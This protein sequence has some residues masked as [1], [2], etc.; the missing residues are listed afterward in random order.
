VVQTGSQQ[1]SGPQYAKARELVRSGAIGAVHRISAGFARN[2]TPGFVAREIEG[3][4]PGTLDWEMWLGPAPAAAFD[5]FRCIYNFRWFWHYSGGQMTNWGAH[6]LDIARLVLGQTGPASVCGLGGRYAIRD[7]GETPDVQEVLYDFPEAN[8]GG[9]GCVVTWSTR[10]IN[11]GRGVPLEFHG[12]KG[13]LT[14]DRRGLRVTPETSEGA[15]QD[16][17]KPLA[18]PLDEQPAPDL[19]GLHVRDF[20]DC[21]KSR[22]KPVADVEEG[23]LSAVVCHLGNIATRLRRSLRWDAARE[24]VVGDAEASAMLH[25]EYRTPF[26]L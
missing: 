22:R 15:G 24:Q 19:D 7:G 9:R 8:L 18:Q 26:R 21:V 12:A 11:R 1:R 25:Y 10:E 16:R 2:A 6:H 14:V 4:L 13:T 20:L 17:E 5:A 23:H 3:G